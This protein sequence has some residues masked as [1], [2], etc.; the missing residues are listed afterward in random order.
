MK[1]LVVEDERYIA[2]PLI[3]ILEKNRY[4]VD[5]ARDGEEG[6]DCALTGIYNLIILDILLPR[7]SGR[8]VLKKLRDK[9]IE[10]PVIMLTALSEIHDK[11][12]GLDLGADDYISK[13]FD[14]EELLARI[15]AVTRRKGEL[16]P[17]D[18]SLS[19]QKTSLDM[20]NLKV[21]G[22]RE[23]TSL[24]LKEAQLLEFFIQNKNLVISKEKIIDKIWSFDSD[25]GD[26]HVEVYISFLRKKL[27]FIESDLKIVTI[28]GAG[29]KLCSED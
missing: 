13:P 5:Y 25:A 4:I 21:R 15:R 29:Y 9:K 6:L 20:K 16:A 22:E 27:I 11:I 3:A 18:S 14:S 1:I 10:T 28:R 23:E 12:L 26:N 17:S 2:E 24:T 19:F 7:L 8:E